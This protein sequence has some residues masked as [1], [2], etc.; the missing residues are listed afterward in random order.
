M[1]V[2]SLYAIPTWTQTARLLEEH[3]ALAAAIGGTPSEWAC[4]RFSVKLRGHPE[5]LAL[6]LDR[7][8]RGLVETMP[9]IARDISVDG[10]DLPAYANGQRYVSKGGREPEQFSDP[11][12]SW[13]HR[14]SIS[15]RSG[16][17]YY[18]FKLHLAVSS[19]TGL[20]LAWEVRTT[21]DQ[22]NIV[23]PSLL[24]KLRE[25]GFE[26]QTI[27]LDKGYDHESTHALCMERASCRSSHCE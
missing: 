7:V 18:G 27:A 12:A 4:Y 15:T 25:R 13:G 22:E 1:P 14:S 5:P 3:A 17:G 19:T 11:D 16:G 26:S 20:P 23:L 8:A 2:K 9:T 6:C 10:S 21:R 24:D